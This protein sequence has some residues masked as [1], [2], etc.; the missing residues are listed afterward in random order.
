[1][2]DICIK[3]RR[4]GRL[5]SE[6][7]VLFPF[8]DV[9][10]VIGELFLIVV[11]ARPHRSTGCFAEIGAELWAGKKFQLKMTWLHKALVIGLALV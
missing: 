11:L 3:Y 8:H 6:W 2:V 9:T 4:N 10:F 1:M 7:F 5:V